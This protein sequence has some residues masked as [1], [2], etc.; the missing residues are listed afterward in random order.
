MRLKNAELAYDIAGLEGKPR[1]GFE[2]E[3]HETL[4]RA[5]KQ[6]LEMDGDFDSPELSPREADERVAAHNQRI[7]AGQDAVGRWHVKPVGG[8]SELFSGADLR[9]P[10]WYTQALLDGFEKCMYIERLRDNSAGF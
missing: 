5:E 10:G 9:P 2:I 1:N 8:D 7:P 4:V 3:K 6:G